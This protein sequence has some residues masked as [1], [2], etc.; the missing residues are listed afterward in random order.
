[1]LL[2]KLLFN[3]AFK[4]KS[5]QGRMQSGAYRLGTIGNGMLEK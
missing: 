1:M 4:K 2:L 5:P 3:A